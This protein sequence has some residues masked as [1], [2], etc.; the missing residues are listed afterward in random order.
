MAK[1]NIGATKS[2]LS[3]FSASYDMVG[4]LM[5]KINKDYFNGIDKYWNTLTAHKY[6]SSMAESLN[7]T[8]KTMNSAFR[9]ANECIQ[10][11]ANNI[12][13]AEGGTTVGS[14]SLNNISDISIGWAG[15]EDGYN[16]PLEGEAAAQTSSHFTA[17]M[18]QIKEKCENCKSAMETIKSSGLGEQIS[19]AAIAD[20]T[21]MIENVSNIMEKYDS[22]AVK[23][24]SNEDVNAKNYK[25]KTS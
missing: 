10:K 18:A 17:P 20:I 9:E 13:S 1:I 8:I 23:S 21:K 12:A 16:L 11:A 22:N 6:F 15:K 19:G 7:S 4:E 14:I 5:L 2:A 3:K 24:A 25:I